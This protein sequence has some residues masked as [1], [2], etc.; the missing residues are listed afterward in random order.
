MQSINLKEIERKA[1]RATYED[2]LWD[3]YFGLMLMS[4]AI[5]MA[6]PES[7]FGPWN[8]LPLLGF[9]TLAYL[10]F[11]AGKKY[12]TLPRMGQV[13]FGPCRRRKKRT[14]IVVL[15]ILVLAHLGI[16]LL[17]IFGRTDP[18][19]GARL[20]AWLGSDD[21]GQLLVAAIG[22][23]FVGPSMLLIAYFKDFPRGYYIAILM[24]MGVFLMLWLNKQ[25]YP[26]L[27]AVLILIPGLV[28]FSLF[29]KKY[30][31]RGAED[32]HG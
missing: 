5:F 9:F 8:I 26:I 27:L 13:V 21:S 18:E 30:P 22:S 15:G 7:G 12:I 32:S 3:I 25:L 29:L 24:S 20:S 11:W 19:F 2:G 4:M 14:M 16:V 23:F 17:S 31:I 1:F 10:V 28:L 6:R